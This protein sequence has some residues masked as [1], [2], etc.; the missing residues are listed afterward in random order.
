MDYEKLLKLVLLKPTNVYNGHWQTAVNTN[1]PLESIP[2]LVDL[3]QEQ[4]EE[5]NPDYT[6]FVVGVVHT[7]GSGEIRATDYWEE[8][9]HVLGHRDKMLFSWGEEI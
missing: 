3:F 1:I 5:T 4:L 8:G 6:G 7:D 2:D 9:V